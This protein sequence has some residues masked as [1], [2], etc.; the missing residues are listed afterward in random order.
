MRAEVRKGSAGTVSVACVVD[1][2]AVATSNDAAYTLGAPD[3]TTLSSGTVSP[4]TSGGVSSYVVPVPAVTTLYESCRAT[5][6]WADGDDVERVTVEF[7]DIVASPWSDVPRPTL[8]DLQKVRPDVHLELDRVGVLLGFA[9]G[10]TAQHGACASFTDLARSE[11]DSKLRAQATEEQQL[12]PALILDR[13]RLKPIEVRLALA[14]LFESIA[15]NPNAPD[16]DAG[17]GSADALARYFRQ[18]AHYQFTSLRCQYD[19]D[20]DLLPDGTAKGPAVG[21]VR[22]RRV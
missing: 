16:D 6:T 17:E 3:G 11:L 21:A 10:T 4:S 15:S 19:L 2:V 5:L 7:F 22:V 8:S 13:D 20:Q 9:S 18:H 1:G 14:L 12:R